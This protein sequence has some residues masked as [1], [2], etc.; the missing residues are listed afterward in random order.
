MHVLSIFTKNLI[1]LRSLQT[2][3]LYFLSARF[4]IEELDLLLNG[5][6]KLKNLKN[7][8]LILGETVVGGKGMLSLASMLGNLKV[9]EELYLDLGEISDMSK[10]IEVLVT[11]LLNCSN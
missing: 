2:L 8:S 10:N 11:G 1:E 9:L 7:L 4:N 3:F 5:I 6:A